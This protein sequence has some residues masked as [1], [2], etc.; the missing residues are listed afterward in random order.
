MYYIDRKMR[1]SDSLSLIPYFTA[2]LI[3][4]FYNSKTRGDS[5]KRTSDLESASKYT[6][7]KN[8]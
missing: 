4:Y 7:L 3:N 5:K 2:H 8:N 1:Y 6:L